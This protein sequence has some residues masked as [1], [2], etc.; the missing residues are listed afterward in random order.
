MGLGQMISDIPNA[1]IS[2]DDTYAVFDALKTWYKIARINVRPDMDISY[3]DQEL[4]LLRICD[5]IW[6][7]K[8]S[9]LA[10][11][12]LALQK[13]VNE[14]QFK[15]SEYITPRRKD[16]PIPHFSR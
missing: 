16:G 2:K 8:E 11:Q 1:A 9:K 13:Q 15:L 14:L 6:G 4:G 5:Q 7:D 10:M 12:V 3:T